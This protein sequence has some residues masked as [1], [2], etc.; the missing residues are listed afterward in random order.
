M[1][2]NKI[3]SFDAELKVYEKLYKIHK[4]KAGQVKPVSE[5]ENAIGYTTDDGTIYIKENHKTIESLKNVL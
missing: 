3:F 2:K 4:R 5:F 1:S